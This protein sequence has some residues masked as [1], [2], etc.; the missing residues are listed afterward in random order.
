MTPA[1]FFYAVTNASERRLLCDE[2]IQQMVLE[3]SG[4]HKKD[5]LTYADLSYNLMQ[6]ATTPFTEYRV[7]EKKQPEKW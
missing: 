4:G 3:V 2:D 7:P 5:R 1:E 6:F